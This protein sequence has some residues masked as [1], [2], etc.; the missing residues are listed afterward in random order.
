MTSPFS[1]WIK[2]YFEK[3]ELKQLFNDF[4]IEKYE[5]GSELDTNH[6]RP[7]MHGLALLIARKPR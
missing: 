1:N 7:H 4:E 3:G 6:G 2:H 5:E